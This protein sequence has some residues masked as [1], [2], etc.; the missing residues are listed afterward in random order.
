VGA[1]ATCT[2]TFN[3]KRSPAKV[4]LETKVLQ[5]RGREVRLDL[6]FSA[7]KAVSARNGVLSIDHQAGL[8]KIAIG[9][10]AAKWAEQILHPPSR[11]TKI[12]V[13]PDWRAAVIGDIDADFLEEL[14]SAAATVT[15]GRLPKDAD[16]VFVGVSKPADF[17]RLAAARTA[18]K[19][20]GAV[21]IIRPKGSAEVSEGAVMSA[22][23]AAGLVDVKVVGF[24][25]THSALKFVVP[26]KDR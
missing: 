13:R 18:I 11:L 14:Q 6:P 20:S 1:E 2:V 10:A 26:L 21:W 12:G 9:A 25:P 19:P 16:A 8:L 24:S 22:G 7:M 5:I 4:R 23:R 3:G 15:T 17:K